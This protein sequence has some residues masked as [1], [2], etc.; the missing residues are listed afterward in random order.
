MKISFFVKVLILCFLFSFGCIAK[1]N[2]ET[3]LKSAQ[4]YQDSFIADIPKKYKCD[5]YEVNHGAALL[6]VQELEKA[7]L[8]K[9]IEAVVI[10]GD[11][12][13]L[14]G[15]LIYQKIREFR[16][17]IGLPCPKF[18]IIR[19]AE[20]ETPVK[21][22]AYT[23]VTGGKKMLHLRPDQ[24]ERLKDLRVL[25]VDDVISTGGTIKALKSLIEGSC[26]CQILGY[27]CIVAEGKDRSSF[28]GKPLFRLISVPFF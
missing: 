6:I 21:S 27:A 2:N 3:S 1:K 23:S 18:C 11:R 14:V 24:Q 16:E 26:N 20:K 4:F 28:E 25:L 12:G 22:V 17:A 15:T 19:S 9:D 13:N 8:L 7:G 10:A 5:N